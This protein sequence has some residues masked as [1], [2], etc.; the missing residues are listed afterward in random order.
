VGFATGKY[1]KFISD[2]SGMAFPYRERVREWNGSIVHIS[3]FEA[4]HPQLTPATNLSDDIALKD[5]K[6]DR[7]EPLVARLLDPNPFLSGNTGTAG[8]T[9]FE[10]SHGRS[11]NDIVRFRE[12]V[13]FDGF[14]KIVLEQAV[15]Y[16]I[17]VIS[18][19]RYTFTAASG[20]ATE[21]GLFGGGESATVGPVTLEN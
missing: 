20:T 3:E 1:A 11:T 19:D 14:S 10:K 2:R 5:A 7:T 13:A 17:T 8:I 9:T 12:V 18:E 6:P 15:G 4:K 16:S 21:G